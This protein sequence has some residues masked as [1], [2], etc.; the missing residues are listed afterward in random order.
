MR[1]CLV[2]RLRQPESQNGGN[3]LQEALE[4]SFPS[5]PRSRSC[6]A[7]LQLPHL[8]P[9]KP[10]VWK[11]GVRAASSRPAVGQDVPGTCTEARS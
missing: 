5:L 7:L 4:V 3:A 1:S 8:I 2:R 9:P 11:G 6:P 10:T